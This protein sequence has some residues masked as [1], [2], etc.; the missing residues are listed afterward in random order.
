MD[1]VIPLGTG[2]KD[3]LELQYALLSI[4]KYLSGYGKI[5]IIG[6]KPKFT[7]GFIHIPAHDTKGRKQ[8]SLMNKL[9]VAA[10]DERIS[11]DFIYYHDDHF[12][13]KPLHVSEIKAWTSGTMQEA[14]NKATGRYYEA[15]KNTCHIVGFDAPYFDLHVP[16]VFNK[17]RLRIISQGD[18]PQFGYVIKSLYFNTFPPEDLEYMA[19]CK[20]NIPMSIEAI[21]EKIKDGLFFSIGANG[22]RTQMIKKLKELYYDN[23]QERTG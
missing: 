17:K 4:E 9:C 22:L 15:V 6:E 16:C 11:E 13:L 2:S 12:L 19:D 21:E 14:L 18:W 8:Y 10:E 20:I 1:I 3:N 23:H 5:F 7:N